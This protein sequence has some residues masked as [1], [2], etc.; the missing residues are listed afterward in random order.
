MDSERWLDGMHY[1]SCSC[2]DLL[3]PR[4][5]RHCPIPWTILPCPQVFFFDSAAIAGGGPKA[6]AG[7]PLSPNWG[8]ASAT[9]VFETHRAVD[10]AL[11]HLRTLP[12]VGSALLGL[13]SAGS[14]VPV[15]PL[16]APRGRRLAARPREQ[17]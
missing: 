6:V 14:P 2:T 16:V 11:R 8:A 9:F 5:A 15:G 13:C 7:G 10:D 1:L 17:L 4:P 12:A 3:L